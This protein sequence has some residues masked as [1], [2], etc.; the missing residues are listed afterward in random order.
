MS[1]H[2]NTLIVGATG[3]VGGEICR[4]LARQGKPTR[5][6]VR[7]SSNPDTVS[8]L[9]T[10]GAEI[11]YGDLKDRDSLDAACRGATAVISTA[12][13][14]RT[15]Q[16]GDS[17]ETVDTQGQLN[18]IEA[19]KAAG[20]EHFIFISF[21]P[22]GLEFPLQSAKRAAEELLKQSG[23]TYT[24]LQ[25]TFFMEVWLGPHLGFEVANAKARIYGAGANKISWIS[26]R[27]VA[28]FAVVALDSA[29]AKNAVIQLGGSEALS[30]LQVVELAEQVTARKFA[31]E[32][33]PD[34][35]LRAQYDAATDPVQKSFAGLMLF[36]AAG[37]TDM[38]EPLQI[39]PVEPLLSVREYLGG[40]AA[41][42][43]A[44]H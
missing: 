25:P 4:L 33:V 22:T 43:G 26:F 9:Q 16:P 10:G 24:I 28:R 15:P 36:Y 8:Q 6:L 21:P 39:L 29:D 1:E 40:A 41:A 32:H 13:A 38:T 11:I 42:A 3:M 23:M 2:E 30:P 35:A 5:A 20:V 12:S 31:V 17:L 37:S 14:T 19:A 27:D 44:A 34:Q 18:I 7:K